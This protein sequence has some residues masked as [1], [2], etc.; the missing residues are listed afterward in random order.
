VVFQRFEFWIKSVPKVSRGQDRCVIKCGRW[1][2][3]HAAIKVHGPHV[4]NF[5]VASVSE[6]HCSGKICRF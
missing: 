3:W 5:Y 1:F 2:L 4:P 6:M